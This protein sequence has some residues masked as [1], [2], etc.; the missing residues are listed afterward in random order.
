[1]VIP[2]LKKSPTLSKIK[3]VEPALVTERSTN[4]E[5]VPLKSSRTIYYPQNFKKLKQKKKIK[6]V[7]KTPRDDTDEE[8]KEF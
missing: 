5:L 3:P 2:S 1:M 8:R 4:M 6:L 7:K